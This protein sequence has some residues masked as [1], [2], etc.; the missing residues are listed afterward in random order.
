MCCSRDPYQGGEHRVFPNTNVSFVAVDEAHCISEWGHDFRPEYRRIR[1]MIDSI[2]KEIPIIAL[3][4]TAT[5]KVQS[6][7]LKN[8]GMEGTNTFVS[9]FNRDNLFYEVRPKV[10]RAN[11]QTDRRLSKPCP[12]SLE[13]F[14]FNPENLQKKLLR[15]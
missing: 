14:M 10:K 9:S 15:F 6:D 2:S 7:I 1:F 11:L 13:S 12:I 5:P 8:L 3:T 4:A